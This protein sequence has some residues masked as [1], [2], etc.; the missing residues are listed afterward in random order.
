M[1][2]TNKNHF[3]KIPIN[4]KAPRQK[5]RFYENSKLLVDFDVQLDF[6]TPQYVYSYDM[7]SFIG[8]DI[9][10]YDENMFKPEFSEN[11][12]FSPDEPLRPKLH[13]TAEFGLINDPNGLVF[14]EGKYHLFFQHNPLGNI[15]ANM[16]WGH[17]VSENLLSWEQLPDAL[18]PDNMGDMWSGSAIVDKQNLLGLNTNEHEALL[19]F[20][21]ASGGNREANAGEPFTQCMAISTD[22]GYTFTKYQKNPIVPF[23]KGKNRDPKVVYDDDSGMYVMVLYIDDGEYALFR[24]STLVDWELIQFFTPVATIECPDLFVCY[25]GDVK[26][27][28]FAGGDSGYLVGDFDINKGLVNIVNHSKYAFGRIYAGQSWSNVSDRILRIDVQKTRELPTEYFNSFLTLPYEVYLKDNTLRVQLAKELK[29]SLTPCLNYSNLSV[30]KFNIELPDYS[31]QIKLTLSALADVTVISLFETDITVNSVT[32]EISF[33]DVIMP[34]CIENKRTEIVIITDRIC[35]EVFSS[36]RYVG[37]TGI[38]TTDKE[39]RLIINGNSNIE[40]LEISTI[41]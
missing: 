23:I 5:L 18:V 22:G 8:K 10:I 33:G 3:L 25:D 35:W 2:I 19:L 17:A 36:D 29:N 7:Y 16:H 6:K 27:W 13:F 31:L 12:S 15:M 40:N 21:T 26:K 1:L 34:C 24:S 11:K 14:Y 39:K 20:Y 37:G 32:N 30:D 41:N 4:P 28:V 38:V 9:E